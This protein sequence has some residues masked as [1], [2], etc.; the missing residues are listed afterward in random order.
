MQAFPFLADVF[1]A[2]ANLAAVVLCFRFLRPARGL[3]DVL[4]DVRAGGRRA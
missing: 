1:P 2:L 3:V 4:A